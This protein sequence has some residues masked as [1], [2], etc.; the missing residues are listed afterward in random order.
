M[1]HFPHLE[2]RNVRKGFVEDDQY[3]RLAE[4]CGRIGIWMRALFECGYVY[5]WRGRNC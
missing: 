2:E 4:S 5:G 1:P 3:H